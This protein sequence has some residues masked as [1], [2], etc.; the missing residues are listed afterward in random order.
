MELQKEITPQDV[1]CLL[2]KVKDEIV[3]KYKDKNNVFADDKISDKG[4]INHCAGLISILLTQSAN[5]KEKILTDEDNDIINKELVYILDTI[6]ET[7]YNCTPLTSNEKLQNNLKLNKITDFV[8]TESLSWVI[9]LMILCYYLNKENLIE[10]NEEVKDKVS[11]TLRDALE[12]ACNIAIENGGWGIA[13]GCTSPDLYFSN[14]ITEAFAD[15]A[16]YILGE[17]EKEI[18]IGADY[19]MK[20]FIGQELIDRINEKRKI[21]SRWLIGNYL[22]ELEKGLGYKNDN[23]LNLYNSYYIINMLILNNADSSFKEEGRKIYKAIEMGIYYSRIYFQKAKD[24]EGWW[25]DEDK[26]TLA[27]EFPNYKDISSNTLK[28]AFNIRPEDPNLVPMSLRSNVLYSFYIS[29]GSDKK[30]DNLFEVILSDKNEKYEIWDRYGYNIFI[31]EKSI[32]AL[33]D[34]YDYLCKYE[35]DNSKEEKLTEVIQKQTIEESLKEFILKIVKE[36]VKENNL[37]NSEEKQ[38]GLK[39]KNTIK[40]SDEEKR[41]LI[42]DVFYELK[43]Y[44]KKGEPDLK[45]ETKYTGI[46]SSFDNFNEFITYL[47]IYNINN[48]LSNSENKVLSNN[49]ILSFSQKIKEIFLCVGKYQ[50]NINDANFSEVFDKLLNKSK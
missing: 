9:S 46:K 19:A 38:L 6:K 11:K 39:N 15:F 29:N 42:R 32:E 30:I 13:N 24:T 44:I 4:L 16:D 27:I 21:T 1:L 10:I 33:I 3:K 17:S 8:F 12:I 41:D 49:D 5:T 14:S 22:E 7:G 35:Q 40:I 23:F 28:K 45:Y 20:E 36:T 26:S 2:N 31:T 18:G 50:K 34:Y 37:Q 48:N 25:A 43:E 47:F